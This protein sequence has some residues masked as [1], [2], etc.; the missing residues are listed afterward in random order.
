MNEEILYLPDFAPPGG[1]SGFTMACSEQPQ[2]RLETYGVHAV[3]DTELVA[4]V[5]CGQGTTPEQAVFTA[6]RL[7]AEAGSI[8]ALLTWAPADYRRM[9]GVS[10]LKGLQFTAIAEI[11]RRM[12]TSQRPAAPVLNRPELIAAHLAPVA[13]SLVVEK[14]W[15]LLL[16]RKSRLLKQVEISSGT[17]T[18]TLAAPREIFR[19]ALRE[20]GPVTG[21]VCAHCHPSGD[22]SPSAPDIQVTRLLREASKAVD[23][24]LIDHVIVGRADADPIGKGYF[25]FRAAGML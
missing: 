3:S 18:A 6:T 13:L 15:V 20:N 9:K 16:D 7:L 14:F 8:G 4:M 17:A 2:H 12:F 21:L 10:H 19:A 25:S 23:I 1:D 24:E 5:L 11:G 22:P